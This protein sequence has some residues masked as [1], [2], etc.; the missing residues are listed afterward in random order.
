M[1]TA[2]NIFKASGK[3]IITYFA[4]FLTSVKPR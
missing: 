1:E 2:E 4:Y 3:E